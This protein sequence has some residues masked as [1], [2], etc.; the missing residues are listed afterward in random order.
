[1]H[2]QHLNSTDSDWRGIQSLFMVRSGRCTRRHRIFK[3]ILSA[4]RVIPNMVK[5]DN[6][7][8][9]R[10]GFQCCVFYHLWL[11]V[12]VFIGHSRVTGFCWQ[13]RRSYSCFFVSVPEYRDIVFG[14]KKFLSLRTG[15]VVGGTLSRLRPSGVRYI[16]VVHLGIC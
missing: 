2:F 4:L 15:K 11:H 7:E 1:M 13:E 14:V 8:T 16:V 10:R 5:H 9:R 3:K 12:A 6:L